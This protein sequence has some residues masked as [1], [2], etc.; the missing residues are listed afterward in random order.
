M[1]CGKLPVYKSDELLCLWLGGR[2]AI[3]H[4]QAF[5]NKPSASYTAVSEGMFNR[6]TT[7]RIP[8]AYS[9]GSAS[10]YAVSSPPRFNLRSG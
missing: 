9:A 5:V 6:D 7:A 4:R 3:W 1:V 2:A 8:A 10:S